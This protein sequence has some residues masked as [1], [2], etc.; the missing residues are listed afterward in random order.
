M[1]ADVG[2]LR[3]PALLFFGIALA[4][5][6]AVFE[7]FVESLPLR[8]ESRTHVFFSTERSTVNTRQE[9]EGRNSAVHF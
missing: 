7:Y 1:S 6:S 2:K 8:E 5:L 4:A 3:P 9:E